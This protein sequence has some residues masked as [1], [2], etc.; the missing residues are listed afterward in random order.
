MSIAVAATVVVLRDGDA[1]LECLML[2]KTQGQA[3]GNAWVFPG[4]RVEPEDGEGD[5]AIRRAAVREAAEE[6]GLRLDAELLSP[7]SHWMPPHDAPRRYSTWFFL[8][9]LPAGVN[10]ADVTTDGG[11][12]A[13]HRWTAPAAA[14]EAHRGG[15]LEL[16]PPTWLTL[17]QLSRQGDVAASLQEAA[18]RP[19]QR[20]STR[21][22]SGTDG[23]GA[24]VLVALWHPDAA[25]PDG[26][27]DPPKPLDTPGPRHR[28]YM[29]PA[30]WR[31]E[32]ST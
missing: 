23:D 6:T 21:M 18:G 25:Y 15:E 16:L 10:P 5:E 20:F 8:A 22:V 31:Y 7:F 4:G 28:L 17:H 3:F 30:G 24:G 2:R 26:E 14:L 1:G 29:D 32:C 27:T 9:P 12:I 13:D 11:E 19:L